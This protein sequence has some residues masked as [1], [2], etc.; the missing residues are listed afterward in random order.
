[1]SLFPR[2]LASSSDFEDGSGLRN[3]RTSIKVIVHSHQTSVPIELG[4]DVVE[5]SFSKTIKGTGKASLVLTPS[6]NYLNKIFPNDYINLYISRGDSH[7]WTRIF[8]GFIDRVSE[9]FKITERGVPQSVYKVACSDFSK[10]FDRTQIYFNPAIMGR[11]DFKSSFGGVNIGGVALFSRGLVAQGSPPDVVLQTV[12]SLLGFGAQFILP[13]SF[14]PNRDAIEKS[15]DSRAKFLAKGT[16]INAAAQNAA[17]ITRSLD[18]A[19]NISLGLATEFIQNASPEAIS[20]RI[21][22]IEVSSCSMRR[23]ISADGVA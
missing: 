12:F 9:S 11:E 7:G 14:M 10:V 19:N 3:Y 2:P 20:R 22:P 23:W 21:T 4:S 6:Q 13:D 16:E 15:R 17:A 1:M 18:V 5:F 8:F